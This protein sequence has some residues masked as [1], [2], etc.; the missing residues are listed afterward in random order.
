[1]VPSSDP[2]GRGPVS[3]GFPGIAGVLS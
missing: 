2:V 3:D 1:V